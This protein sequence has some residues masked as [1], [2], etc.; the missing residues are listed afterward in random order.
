[1]AQK[2]FPMVDKKPSKELVFDVSKYTICPYGCQ[3]SFFNYFWA[4]GPPAGQALFSPSGTP[5]YPRFR[6]GNCGE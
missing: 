5:S 3:Q 6:S 1:M 2:F 4:P